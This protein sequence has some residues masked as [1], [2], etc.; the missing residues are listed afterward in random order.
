MSTHPVLQDRHS[1]QHLSAGVGGLSNISMAST[2]PVEAG[3][4]LPSV[5][6][7]CGRKSS[8]FSCVLEEGVSLWKKESLVLG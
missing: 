2:T 6:R 4:A 3:L 1:H 8:Y 7:V 5:V